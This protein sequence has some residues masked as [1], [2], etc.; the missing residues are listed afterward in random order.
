MDS[1]GTRCLQIDPADRFQ[2]T[3][4]LAA[5]L[6]RLDADGNLIPEPVVRRFT[7]KIAAAAAVLV[8]ALVGGTYWVARGPAEPPKPP[9]PVS[10][11]IADFATN[12]QDP[13][14]DGLIEQA[15]AVGVEGA[16]FVSAYPRRDALRLAGQIKPGGHLDDATAVLVAL[17]EGVDRVITG[18]IDKTGD[19]YK[20]SVLVVNPGDNKTLLTWDTEAASKDVVLAAVGKAA[21]KLRQELGDRTANSDTVKSEETFTAASLDAARAYASGQEL[22]WAGKYDEAFAQYQ[23]AAKLDPD[24]GAPTRGLVPWPTAWA[25]GRKRRSTSSRHWRAPGA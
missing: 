1:L 3:D 14:F 19:A 21:A 22:Q 23:L 24:M 25:G 12:A 8:A 2:T 11:L 5:A 9:E 16:S 20:L 7:S 6:D 13:V 17:R 18:A 10:V 15:L 4:E